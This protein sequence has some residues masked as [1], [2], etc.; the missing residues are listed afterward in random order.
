MPGRH[1]GHSLLQELPI[2][3][4]LML[5]LVEVAA[6]GGEN[7]GFLGDNGAP[8]R[9]RKTGKIGFK[10]KPSIKGGLSRI[11]RG[12][13]DERDKRIKRIRK[14]GRRKEGKKEE[15]SEKKRIVKGP[16]DLFGHLQHICIRCYGNP[17]LVQLNTTDNDCIVS[18]AKPKR[19]KIR[20]FGWGHVIP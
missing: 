14:K 3:V 7:G 4:Q 2:V 17:R 5:G 8:S 13:E 15:K 19:K 20:E 10:R 9:A 16:T 1:I 18:E 12:N 6:V 11:A